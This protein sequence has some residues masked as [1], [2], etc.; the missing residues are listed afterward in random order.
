MHVALFP[1]SQFVLPAGRMALRV[2]EPRYQRLVRE[3]GQRPFA[4]ALLNPYVKNGH[5]DR[6][7]PIVTEVRIIDFTQLADGLLGITV[8]GIRR[9]RI[10]ERWQEA[11]QLHVASCQ[12]EPGWPVQAYSD[13]DTLLTSA[14]QDVFANN[15]A[16]S[17]LYPQ[18][19]WHSVNWLVQRWLEI[20]TMPV[21]LKTKLVAQPDASMAQDM[22]RQWLHEQQ[23]PAR[24]N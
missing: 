14:L 18:P 8:E 7:L 24:V 3:A 15:P 10:C 16:L 19:E 20:L 13:D 21:H 17:A 6:I 1:L 9:L 2:F 12:P 11:D 22:L 4:M 23:R 5:P